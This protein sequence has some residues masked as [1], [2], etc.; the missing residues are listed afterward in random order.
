MQMEQLA[1]ILLQQTFYP[2]LQ[3][4]GLLTVALKKKRKKET[5]HFLYMTLRNVDPDLDWALNP[6][7]SFS[8]CCQEHCTPLGKYEEQK[9]ETSGG[10]KSF[11]NLSIS[12]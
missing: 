8:L 3:S 2:K 11:P 1:M 5:T 12:L 10:T 6:A 7:L 9:A 4:E